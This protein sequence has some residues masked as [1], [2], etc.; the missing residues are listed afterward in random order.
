MSSQFNQRSR[1]ESV[2]AV[3][4]RLTSAEKVRRLQAP[5]LLAS[6]NLLTSPN[7]NARTRARTRAYTRARARASVCIQVRWVRRLDR[8][9]IKLIFFRP[10]RKRRL[11]RFDEVR[12]G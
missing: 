2:V 5:Y 8:E 12:H 6:P 1:K 7:L 4:P 9:L 3:Q 10:T 11:G